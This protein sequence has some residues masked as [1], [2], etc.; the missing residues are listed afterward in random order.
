MGLE[1]SSAVTVVV[2]APPSPPIN[3]GVKLLRPKE[4][5]VSVVLRE[6]TPE[7]EEVEEESPVGRHTWACQPPSARRPPFYTHQQGL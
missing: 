5:K 7:E 2:V 4:E 1:R 6:A 3:E